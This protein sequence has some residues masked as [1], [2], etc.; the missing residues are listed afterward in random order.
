[1]SLARKQLTVSSGKFVIR[2]LHHDVDKTLEGLALHG[3]CGGGTDCRGT[4]RR[5]G[6]GIRGG[7]GHGLGRHHGETGE[8]SEEGLHIGGE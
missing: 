7:V 6:R 3:R 2:V 8:D 4:L 5:K 1:M